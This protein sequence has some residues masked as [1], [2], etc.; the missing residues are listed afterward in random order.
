MAK[1]RTE[2]VSLEGLELEVEFNGFPG[3]CLKMYMAQFH[4]STAAV[5]ID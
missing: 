5:K 1:S 2:N 4:I 3:K